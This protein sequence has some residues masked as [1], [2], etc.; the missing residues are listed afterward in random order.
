MSDT[1]SV[2]SAA[3]EKCL[4][5]FDIVI[6]GA[7]AAGLMAAISAARA[8]PRALRI[9]LLDG[10]AQIGAKILMSGGTRCN[11]T[12]QHVRPQ[13]FQGGSRH[14][15]QHVLEAFTGEQA[16]DFFRGLGVE[17]VLEAGGKYFPSTHSGRTILDVLVNEVA[18]LGVTLHAGARVTGLVRRDDGFHVRTSDGDCRAAAVILATGGLSYPTTGSDGTGHRL[19]Q[20]LGHTLV[21]TSPALTPLTTDDPLWPTLSGVSL[22]VR[23]TLLARGKTVASYTDAFLFTHRGFS[24]PAALNISRHWVRE[25]WQGSVTCLTSFLPEEDEERFR[26]AWPPGEHPTQSIKRWLAARLP[27]RLTEALLQ[28]LRI[29]PAKIV[30][31]LTREERRRL[32]DGLF[33]YPLEISGVIGYQK[34]EVT[35]GGVDLREIQPATMASRLVPGLYVV[36]EMLDVDGRIGGFNFQWA[37]ST[38]LLAGRAAAQAV[39]GGRGGQGG[40]RLPGA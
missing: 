3:G 30:N 16:A 4:T 10:R 6:V 14:V 22:P 27:E 1:F 24:G 18:R 9:L 11:V 31:Q 39:S 33:R 19:A 7:G 8:A 28:K 26:A 36:G 29:P 37:W 17:L 34:A 25:G 23:V 40:Q 5:L 35:A 32:I 12:N 13:D 21:P 2:A 20:A 15:I 38:G